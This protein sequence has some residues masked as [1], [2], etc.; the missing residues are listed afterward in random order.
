MRFLSIMVSFS[1][2]SLAFNFICIPT[3]T[4]PAPTPWDTEQAGFTNVTYD[5]GLVNVGGQFLAWGDYNNDGYQDLLVNGRRLFRNSGPPSWSFSEVTG[6]VGLSGGN[7]GTWADWN[8]DGYLDIYVAGSDTLYRNNGPPIYH[9]TDVTT[10]AGIMRESHSTGCGWGDYDNDGDVDLFKIMGEDSSSGDYVWFPNS[11]W[12]NEGDGTFTNVTVE[13]GVDESSDP[14]YSRGVSWADYN[15]DGWQDIYISNYRQLPNYLYENNGDG[16]FTEVAAQKN[17]ADGPPYDPGNLDPYNRP[18]HGVGSVWGDYDGDG[19]LDLWVTNLNHKDFRTS[20]DSLLYHNDG[21]PSYSFTNMRGFSGIRIK[22][23]IIPGEGDELFVGCAWGDFDNDGDLDLFLPQIYDIDYAYSFLYMNNCDGTFTD[24]TEE[25]GVR[26]WDTY[27]GCWCDYDNDGDLDLLTSGRDSGG[28]GDPHFV[29]LFRNDGLSGSWLHLDLQGD[30][31][32]TNSAAIGARVTV[33]APG[34]VSI[35]RE[36]EGGMGPHGMQNSLILEYGFGTYFQTVDIEVRWPGGSTQFIENVSLNQ[37]LHVSEQQSH[38]KITE[39]SLSDPNPIT[40]ELI[41]ITATV[42][43]AGTA[44]ID[45]A[46]VRF[47]QDEIDAANQI[48]PTTVLFNLSPD[49]EDT[50]YVDWDTTGISDAHTIYVKAETQE[51]SPP[52]SSISSKSV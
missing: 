14:K 23:Y 6:Q 21:P 52:G 40:G 46:E 33:T 16:T 36:V 38:I 51:P 31:V 11:F 8:N 47:Y 24:I 37:L 29:H 15:D 3:V 48:Q 26:V 2:M 4:S 17:V 42:K 12:R 28:N 7:Y 9:F 13:A 1:L 39:V 20:D 43:N 10:Q 18:G 41:R 44:T 27:A 5:A 49:E 30:G 19:Y 25:A 22:P 45:A 35:I 34:G 50:A 32:F